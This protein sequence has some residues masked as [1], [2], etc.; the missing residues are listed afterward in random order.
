MH[1]GYGAASSVVG[2]LLDKSMTAFP[3][4]DI[5]SRDDHAGHVALVTMD[6][7]DFK[8]STGCAGEAMSRSGGPVWRVVEALLRVPG[9]T[10]LNERNLVVRM[11]A[12][13]WGG[14][15]GVQ[16]HPR[17]IE[18]LF[19]LVEACRSH[20]H[21]LSTLVEILDRIYQGST[22]LSEIHRVVDPMSV[23]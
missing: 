9:L 13:A 17:A 18:H 21:G 1:V 10:E 19:S 8:R 4:R 22:F 6:V 12:D 14:P 7:Q 2:V 11:L 23:L 15:V 5:R 16:E 20:P 3:E